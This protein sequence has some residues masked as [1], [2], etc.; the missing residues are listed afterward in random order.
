MKSILLVLV[1]I[2]NVFGQSNLYWQ[3]KSFAFTYTNVIPLSKDEHLLFKSSDK[4][5]ITSDN[6]NTYQNFAD[7]RLSNYATA[8][9]G[10]E[11]IFVQDKNGTDYIC[12]INI[13]TRVVKQYSQLSAYN[14]LNCGDT[15]LLMLDDAKRIFSS[16]DTAKS[17]VYRDSLVSWLYTWEWDKNNHIYFV[18][19][20][21]QLYRTNTLF[22][23]N[24]FIK[25]VNEAGLGCNDIL[26]I[27]PDSIL[28]SNRTAAQRTI[29]GGET[30]ELIENYGT[31]GTFELGEDGAIYNITYSGLFRTYDF[32]ENWEQLF[33]DRTGSSSL[34]L[35]G[36]RIYM[37]YGLD[38]YYSFWYDPEIEAP[39][40]D[41]YQPLNSENKWMYL[42]KSNGVITGVEFVE[43]SD[44]SILNDKLY[45]QLSNGEHY[46]R[47]EENKLFYQI[48]DS[49][50]VSINFNLNQG[51]PSYFL[52]YEQSGTIGEDY[53]FLF[54]EGRYCKGLFDEYIYVP[55]V[56]M[57]SPDL[58]IVYTHTG[59]MDISY[60]SESEKIL[61]QAIINDDSGEHFYNDSPNP[62][63]QFAPPQQLVGAELN[64][65]V[66]V[67]HLFSHF[68]KNS[69]YSHIKQASMEYYYSNG[70]SSTVSEIF[71][72]IPLPNSYY[73]NF[74]LPLKTNL[75]SDG[76]KFYFRIY[77]EDKSM[78]PGKSV[79]PNAGF[80]SLG[81]VPTAFDVENSE[82]SFDLEQNYPNPFNPST[83]ITY[84]I[85]KESFVK[86]E[87]YN[88]QGEKV[89]EITSGMQSAGEYSAEFNGED[90]ASGVY[91]ARINAMPESGGGG[92]NKIIKM[93][94]VK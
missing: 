79:Y 52:T 6:F 2:G 64:M 86:L 76:F 73:Y 10:D 93:V 60:V 61:V 74:T 63:F 53:R 9:V 47:Y 17:W 91:F 25:A 49:E 11:V 81:W 62:A 70:D 85:A 68:N 48:A 56:E 54:D 58:G 59:T 20:Q 51:Q 22:G 46:F 29:D 38:R 4:I 71:E 5:M 14:F 75:L 42:K 82:L 7:V 89:R 31:G 50:N 24:E 12:K 66:R 36:D 67:Y 43:V 83:K 40:Y 28:I 45:Y 27:S 33:G 21:N 3:K 84:S 57:Y 18:L 16:S 39:E 30:W 8:K 41:N 55:W 23:E 65:D 94:L 35:V 90:L 92:F 13:N 15:L 37:T 77:A 1:L 88:I 80:V 78:V 44:S 69:G 32:G 72:G 87:I 19:N 26:A 34:Y